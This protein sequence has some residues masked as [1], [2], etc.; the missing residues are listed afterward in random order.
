MLNQSMK[1]QVLSISAAMNKSIKNTVLL[2]LHIENLA[3]EDLKKLGFKPYATLSRE[4]QYE[5]ELQKSA[6]AINMT[7][8]LGITDPLENMIFG[9][10]V[11][12]QFWKLI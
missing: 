7:Q 3:I 6:Y 2:C 12:F 8:K 11:L 10:W 9:E 1:S 5:L 4:E